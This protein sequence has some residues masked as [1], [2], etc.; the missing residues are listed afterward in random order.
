MRLT[1]D[2]YSYLTLPHPGLSHSARRKRGPAMSDLWG[3]IYEMLAGDG[4]LDSRRAWDLKARFEE[5]EANVMTFPL[6]CGQFRDVTF[7]LREDDALGPQVRF[8]QYPR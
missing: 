5:V 7:R 2:R 6:N 1:I 3:A 4:L 8:T